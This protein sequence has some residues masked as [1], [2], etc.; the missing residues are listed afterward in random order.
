MLVAHRRNVSA[1][2]YSEHSEHS[3]YSEYSGTRNPR[4]DLFWPPPKPFRSLRPALCSPRWGPSTGSLSSSAL[5]PSALRERW[6]AL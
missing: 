3:E 5:E 2:L 1:I 6:W 4:F